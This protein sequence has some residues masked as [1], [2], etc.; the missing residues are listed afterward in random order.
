MAD[1]GH[2]VKNTNYNQKLLNKNMKKVTTTTIAA[3]AATLVYGSALAGSRQETYTDHQ[4]TNKATS[5]K[6]FDGN[7]ARGPMEAESSDVE[8][9]ELANMDASEIQ[10]NKSSSDR[11]DNWYETIRSMRARMDRAITSDDVKSGEEAL[12]SMEYEVRDW[13]RNQ[14][15][16][17]SMDKQE[18]K[19]ATKE[20]ADADR[21]L[22]QQA[23]EFRTAVPEDATDYEQNLENLIADIEKA[24]EDVENRLEFLS[25]REEVL[26]NVKK[27]LAEVREEAEEHIDSLADV[28]EDNWSETKQ[29]ID[30]WMNE[31]LNETS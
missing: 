26:E 13:K 23:E 19:E 2:F 31:T 20:I 27:E 9:Y 28:S 29:S 16:L 30:S 6:T 15:R 4:H 17:N 1:T 18:R 3:L 22:Q 21:T 8:G 5:E 14:E 7:R 11:L 25:N 24:E 10:F 12:A